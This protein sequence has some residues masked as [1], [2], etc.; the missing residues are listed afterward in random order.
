M[1]DD[2]TAVVALWRGVFGYDEA[3]ND[4]ERVLGERVRFDSVNPQ[5][6]GVLVAV[7]NGQLIGTLMYGYDGHRG[8]LYRLAVAPE[9]RRHGVG[10]ALLS[11]AECR[12]RQ[13]GCAKINL[14][15]HSHNTAAAAF[16]MAVG[17]G[18]EARVSLGKDLTGEHP[19]G[20]DAGC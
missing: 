6:G 2:R 9:R 5:A 7:A 12:L 16:W 8:W 14:Q 3:R 17:Y 10:R 20:T 15:V 19:P 11:E 1:P 4:P 18:Q 13:L